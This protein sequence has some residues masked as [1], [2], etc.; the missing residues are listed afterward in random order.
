MIPPSSG[1]GKVPA[2]EPPSDDDPLTSGPPDY[3]AELPIILVIAA[4]VPTLL[5]VYV[6]IR[7]LARFVT[8]TAP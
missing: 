2:S 5:A 1:S 3:D 7:A 6:G 4:S 8:S